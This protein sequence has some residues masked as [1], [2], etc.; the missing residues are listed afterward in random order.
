MIIQSFRGRGV[1][2][3]MLYVLAK[4]MREFE[5]AEQAE[6]NEKEASDEA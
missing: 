1:T 4:R 6:L 5:I 2:A 3:D